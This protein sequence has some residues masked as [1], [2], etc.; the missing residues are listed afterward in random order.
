[1]TLFVAVMVHAFVYSS[2]TTWAFGHTFGYR[3][4]VNAAPLL[5]VGAGL[6][7]ARF[8]PSARI[9]AGVLL[10]ILVCWNGLLMIS[11]ETDRIPREWPVAHGQLV[12]A[13][14]DTLRI[15]AAWLR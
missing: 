2:Y 3:I 5:A 1:M 11:Y 7:F 6:S 13:Q 12:G 8:G 9:L 15:L 10:S 4:L 14:R